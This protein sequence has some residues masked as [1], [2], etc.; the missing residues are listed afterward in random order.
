MSLPV[1][2]PDQ[3]HVEQIRRHLWSGR[4]FGRAAVMIGSGFSLNSVKVNDSVPNFP[5]WKQLAEKMFDALYPPSAADDKSWQEA[6]ITKISGAPLRL[7]SE[8]EAA[9]TRPNLDDLLINAIPDSAYRPGDLH[10]LLLSLPWSDIFTTNYDT[11]LERTRPF[12]HDRKYDLILNTSDIPVVSRPRIVKLHGSFPSQRPFI[13][14]E[15]DFRTYPQKFSPFVNLVQQSIMESVFCLLGFSGDDPNFLSWTGWVRDHLGEHAPPVYLCGI[16][17][18]ST[19]QRKLLEGRKVVPVDLSPLF[20]KSSWPNPSIRHAKALEWFLLTLLYG[21]PPNIIHWPKSVNEIIWQPSEG[22]HPIPSGPRPLSPLGEKS[23]KTLAIPVPLEHL[24]TIH[25]TWQAKRKEYPGWAVAPQDNRETLWHYTE[26]WFEPILGSIGQLAPPQNLF[27]LYELNW[28]LERALTPYP[29]P[30]AERILSVIEQFN[31]FPSRYSGQAEFRPDRSEYGA[32]DWQQIA[33]CWVELLFAVIRTWRENLNGERF[34]MTMEAIKET[35]RQKPEWQCRWHYEYCLFFLAQS[36]FNRVRVA[37]S[38]WKATPELPFWETRRAAV[39]AEIGDLEDARQTAE[40]ALA[41]IRSR[42]IPG[43]TDYALLSQEGWT[44]LLLRSIRMNR[45][46]EDSS[47]LDQFTD[48]WEKL[49]SYRC[50]PWPEIETLETIV[51][52]MVPPEDVLRETRRGYHPKTE[53]VTY[54]IVAETAYSK[55]QPAFNFLR[56]FEEG[57]IPIRAGAIALFTQAV[58]NAA[59]CISGFSPTWA[60][61]LR[62]RASVAPEKDNWPDLATVAGFSDDEVAYLYQIFRTSFIEA[63]SH[64]SRHPEETGGLVASTAL[65]RAITF[66]ELLSRLSPRLPEQQLEDLL[67]L[68]VD[69]YL[70]PIAQ[71][72][73]SLHEC[74][75]VL[76][77]RG[78]EAATT[79]QK[80]RLLPQLLSLPI[81]GEAGFTVSLPDR[82]KDPFRYFS[83]PITPNISSS[84]DHSSL[85]SSISNL[86]RIVKDGQAEARGRAIRRLVHLHNLKVLTNQ[87][88][89]EFTQALWARL[90]E[91]ALP[92]D[93][94]M[95]KEAFLVLPEP[96][97]GIAKERLKTDLLSKEFFRSAHRISSPGQEGI[98]FGLSFGTQPLILELCEATAFV[99]LR[100]ETPSSYGID[101]SKEEIITLLNRAISWWNDQKQFLPQAEAFHPFASDNLRYD[102]DGIV[103]ILMKVILP[104][105]SEVEIEHR[106]AVATLVNELDEAG[107]NVL[108]VWPL[109]LHLDPNLYDKV[110]KRIQAG[111]FAN[112]HDEV[113]G[114]SLG[115][116]VWLRYAIKSDFPSPPPHLLDQFVSI[117]AARRQPGLDTALLY[118]THLI[119]TVPEAFEEK[120]VGWILLGLSALL[121]ETDVETVHDA[122]SIETPL[123]PHL[124]IRAARLANQLWQYYQQQGK[125][126]PEVLEQ[127]HAAC[128]IDPL[129]QVR[130]AWTN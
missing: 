46:G 123:K 44:M 68:A 97:P 16:L 88:T 126:I 124:R 26:Y 58:L 118:L 110:V 55:L 33:G 120:H 9:F 10:R 8:Y 59:K 101:W 86:I 45:L 69:V 42:F 15:E 30:H 23:P 103:N 17:S 41:G 114:A 63:L 56:I 35:M 57:G 75:R 84:L 19:F 34:L 99:S 31:P 38:E 81:P 116:R 12:I 7:A 40:N 95:P 52:G 78:M 64:L 60:L 87:E 29:V 129:V 65:R 4:E 20:P 125:A 128:G 11:L 66:A 113:K 25:Q 28:R 117:V 27:L 71:S 115:L 109:V 49:T 112:D 92:A 96:K 98:S 36:D 119:Q 73:Y 121:Y 107:V 80:L 6:R 76:F 105:I 72:H 48:R 50:N 94:Y 70:V 104:R 102:L 91:A 100:G 106:I 1:H 74:H 53:R 62:L 89:E 14:T 130:R 61:S 54:Q 2:F 67:Q 24:E 18:L 13:I 85:A 51:K 108:R 39:L 111:L 3:I 82:W 93:T 5:I 22:V 127:W 47:Y 43:R 79:E 21:R 77:E 83:L 32:W 90:D 122:S 37:L